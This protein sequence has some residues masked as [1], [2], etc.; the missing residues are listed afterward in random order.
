[1]KAI[2]RSSGAVPAASGT[3]TGGG[4][5]GSVDDPVNGCWLFKG[6]C[7]KADTALTAYREFVDKMGRVLRVEIPHLKVEADCVYF[8]RGRQKPEVSRN[9][10]DFCV[11]Q[12]DEVVFL[13]KAGPGVLYEKA[14]EFL[15]LREASLLFVV[16]ELA[17]E[18]SVLAVVSRVHQGEADLIDMS[19]QMMR[20]RLPSNVREGSMV[21]LLNHHVDVSGKLLL[22]AERSVVR[23]YDR[24]DPGFGAGLRRWFG[25]HGQHWA[26]R[27]LQRTREHMASREQHAKE[28]Q[29]DGHDAVAGPSRPARKSGGGVGGP[30]RARLLEEDVPDSQDREFVANDDE[31]LV[32]E[33][34]RVGKW[35]PK[36]LDD[37]EK[38]HLPQGYKEKNRFVVDGVF[39]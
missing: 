34:E 28:Q 30:K 16:G 7:L 8:V 9:D 3:A 25:K 29:R 22:S 31:E 4:I 17:R 11:K 12:I 35:T 10:C 27:E 19:Y 37:F 14:G 5:C 36:P 2:P 39:G 20:A 26:A 15:P 18:V 24:G 21:A 6:K 38:K 1:M 33:D 23:V 32:E 13:E